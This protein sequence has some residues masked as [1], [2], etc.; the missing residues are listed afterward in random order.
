MRACLLSVGLF[1]VGM[2]AAA[3]AQA[4]GASSH[5]WQRPDGAADATLSV[6]GPRGTRQFTFA[7]TESVEVKVS[8]LG[9]DGLYHWHLT[10]APAISEAL[11]A[12]AAQRREAGDTSVVPGWPA[13]IPASS[14]LLSVQA[15]QFAPIELSQNDDAPTG[16]E[17]DSGEVPNDQ[18]IADDLIV[19]GSTCSGFDCLNNESFGADTLRLK[20]NNLRINFDDT[21][22]TGTFPANDW[23]IVANDQANG[24]ANYLAFEDSTVGR[25]PF[26][27]EAGAPT[28]ALRVDS[29]GNI[30][31]G[32]DT[33]ILDLHAVDGDT[34]GLRLDQDGSVGY[35]PQ[36]WDVAGNETNFF[37]RDVTG[38]SRLPF[39]IRP[40]APTSAIDI[41]GSGDV[42][43][44]IA[45][46]TSAVHIRRAATFSGSLLL[47]D[48][49]DDADPLTEDRRLALDSDGNLFVGGTITQLSSRHSKENLVAVAGSTLL[50]QLRQLNLW[51]W[52]YRSS[53]MA[54]RHMGP[55]AED[56]YRMFGLGKDERSVAPADMAGVALAASQAL[57]A[58]IEQRDRHIA[59][60]EAR[61]ARLESALERID[62]AKN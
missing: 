35:S 37:I 8:M 32:T 44:G 12:L 24:G 6:S 22:S 40:G 4:E 20:E 41:A 46:P 27:V 56:F 61:I 31:F 14:G 38:A 53:S 3:L 11:Q 55:V 42:G 25:M 51:T 57:S 10:F 48:V 47:A 2:F 17:G 29:T 39:R 21:S 45:A 28:D 5:H 26:L 43:F 9:G 36:I 7:A 23:R 50:S 18:V 54:D 49:P 16:N 33:P 1:L 60:L 13:P 58:E 30:G 62:G 19:Q 52:N 34:P 59:E 15:G